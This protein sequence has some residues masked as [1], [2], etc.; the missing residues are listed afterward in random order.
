MAPQ[1]W[2][3]S[4][5]PDSLPSALGSSTSCYPPSHLCSLGSGMGYKFRWDAQACEEGEELL[6]EGERQ[7]RKKE[8][9]SWRLHCKLLSPGATPG[10]LQEKQQLCLGLFSS[11]PVSPTKSGERRKLHISYKENIMW[12]RR[13]KIMWQRRKKLL[14][15]V[16]NI[17]IFSHF[18]ICFSWPVA[19]F[20]MHLLP[21]TT[22][23][24]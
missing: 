9:N 2:A 15:R 13:K 10:C 14:C 3:R 22:L 12:Q 16:S 11:F 6:P 23:L 21:Q 18:L 8:W 24:I 17:F 20:C 5:P 19:W 4:S 7:S 1:D